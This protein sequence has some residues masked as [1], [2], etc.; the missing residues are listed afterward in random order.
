M[1]ANFQN[2]RVQ[3]LVQEVAQAQQHACEHA[4]VQTGRGSQRERKGGQCN[5]AFH[6]RD[7]KQCTQGAW[8]D[9]VDDGR[10]HHGRQRCLRYV[11]EH[12]GEPQHT[13]QHQT[14]RKDGG[15]ARLGAG[16]QRDGRAGK[17]SADG[18]AATQPGCDLGHA[19]GDQVLVFIPA[20]ALFAVL[21]LGAG[22]YFRK[23]TRLTISTGSKS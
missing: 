1:L 6:A 22:G 18:K 10:H 5:A 23:L 4:P 21:D 9:E 12:R 19:L 17:R 11:V 20:C 3:A 7:A 13:D 2:A 15:P 16:V 8:L 14:N